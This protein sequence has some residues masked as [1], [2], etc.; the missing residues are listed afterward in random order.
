MS[1]PDDADLPYSLLQFYATSAYPC[2]YLADREADLMPLMRR[3]GEIIGAY[4]QPEI[5][6]RAADA[7]SGPEDPHRTPTED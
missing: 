7:A 6:G 4:L 1:R 5:Y 3:A 2:S